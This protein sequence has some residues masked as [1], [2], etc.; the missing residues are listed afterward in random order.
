MR[1][2]TCPHLARRTS[3]IPLPL[4]GG[5]CRSLR[6]GGAVVTVEQE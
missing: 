1:T 6:F 5:L 3:A 2:P 4:A